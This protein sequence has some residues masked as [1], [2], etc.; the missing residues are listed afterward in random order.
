[1]NGVILELHAYL[2][3]CPIEHATK[4]KKYLIK[5]LSGFI[6]S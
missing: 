4:L 6:T 1:M 5:Q 3:K 2:T